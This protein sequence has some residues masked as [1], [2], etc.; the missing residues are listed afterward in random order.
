MSFALI[1][2]FIFGLI[3]SG[4]KLLSWRIGV[5]T[6]CAEHFI[7]QI[8]C[9]IWRRTLLI[10]RHLSHWPLRKSWLGWLGNNETRQ[11]IIHRAILPSMMTTTRRRW[12]AAMTMTT[13]RRI[14]TIRR[15][16][17]RN[18]DDVAKTARWLENRAAAIWYS[19]CDWNVK[20]N[21]RSF[22]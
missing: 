22:W 8:T 13:A 6:K 21:N 7:T 16:R 19:C 14:V 20:N 3:F 10:H 15:C 1:F 11:R 9:R 12:L 2:R 5:T 17:W 18:D 4:W